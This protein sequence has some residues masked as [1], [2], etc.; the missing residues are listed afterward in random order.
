MWCRFDYVH[1]SYDLI[2]VF[3]MHASFNSFQKFF[4]GLYSHPSCN[5]TIINH[6]GFPLLINTFSRSTLIRAD[7]WSSNSCFNSDTW[8][9]RSWLQARRFAWKKYTWRVE[10][11]CMY[12]LNSTPITILKFLKVHDKYMK[13]LKWWKCRR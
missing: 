1:K 7:F 12:L 10:Y 9:R 8:L 2:L 5:V 6:C 4:F 11:M 3:F 13:A